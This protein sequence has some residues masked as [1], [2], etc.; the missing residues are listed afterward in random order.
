[1]P[2]PIGIIRWYLYIPYLNQMIAQKVPYTVLYF[3]RNNLKTRE[4]IANLLN[5]PY[6][7]GNGKKLTPEMS[8][9]P[10]E[11]LGGTRTAQ[12]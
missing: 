2:E 1:M 5:W 8:P 3:F 4:I 11:P 6:V 10:R 12:I 9:Y 7:M